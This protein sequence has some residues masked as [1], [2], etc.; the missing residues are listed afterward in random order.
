MQERYDAAAVEQAAQAYW[1]QHQ[2]YLARE[3]ASRPKYYCLSMF[4]YPSGRL[5]M[6]HVRNY[7]IGDVLARFMRMRGC[8]VLQPMG[9]DAFGL[10]AEN[11][12][13]ANGVPPAAWTR[14]NIDYMR[15]QLRSLGFAIDW[16]RELATCDPEYYRWNQWLFLR[17]LERGIAYKRTGLVNWDPVDKTV[18]ANEQVIDGRGWR[19][20]APVEK[21]EIPMYY[22]RITA[23]AEELLAAL[24]DLPGWP[25]RVRVMQAHWIGR[26]EGVELAFPY[27]AD[28]CSLL[29][30]DGALKVFTTRADTLFGVTFVAVSAEHPLAAAAAADNAPL[31][32]FVDECRRG[33]TMEADVAA[34]PKRGM[35]TGLHV[36]HPFGGQPIEVWVANYVLMAYGEG[37]VMGVP[38]HDERDFDF[39]RSHGIP[40]RTVVQSAT[41]AYQL[42]GEQWQDAYRE[43]G[44][45]IDSGRFSGLESSAAID[46]ITAALEQLGLG[47]KRVQWRLR[48]WGI[49]RQRYWGCPIPLIHCEQCGAVPVPD[50]Q[51]PVV[52]PENLVPDGS[53]NPL[54]RDAAFVN[55][56]CPACG[57]PARRETDTMDTF[58]DS[59][60]YFLRFASADQKSAPVDERA[61]Y[62]LPVDQYIG[63]IEHAILHLL[64]SRFWTRVMR[65]MG[66]VDVSEPFA[67]LLTQGMVLNHI[68]YRAPAQ[69][70]R[71]FFNPAEVQAK[72]DAAGVRT[73]GVLLADQ[74]PVEYGGL[75][76]MS[77]SKNNGVDPQTLV[78][79]YGADTARLFMMFAAPPEQSLEWSDDGVQG[80]ARFLRRLWKAVYDHV[81]AGAAPAP[82][83]AAVPPAA[84]ELRRL[85][86]QTLAK[87][88]GDIARRRTFNTAIAAVMELLNAVGHYADSGDAARVVRQEALE[89]A[90]LALSPIVP[91]ICH[92]LW[93]ALGHAGAVIDEPWP[94]P[95]PGALAQELVDLVVQVNGKLRGR[96]RL[97]AGAPRQVAVDAALADPD[98][99]RF[100][101]GKE[102]RRAV[103]VPDKLVNLVV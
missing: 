68:Y 103:H 13:I 60:W 82:A 20:G 70:R 46:A 62:W 101:A 7:T 67:R 74:Q 71:Q 85:A 51:L 3:D 6:G 53:G 64:Y 75:G 49:S 10:P 8:N 38:A 52:L 37:A 41:G 93:H 83:A 86:H 99:Q 79:K 23:Y 95:D 2:S 98:V 47:R 81:A 34:A 32:A 31:A 17:M 21:R 92:A 5:H 29:G 54:L 90:V 30:A 76:T 16:R 35:P 40:I 15:R 102:I 1:E 89:I 43:P 65:D 59:S 27:A 84:R 4:P 14:D 19:T 39:A 36:R 33:S 94:E 44:V 48:D 55:V 77:K 42:V 57:R 18:L 9:W 61:K 11:A 26:S 25:E 80:Q 28:T 100:I 22:L 72:F 66:L 12:A 96:V 45:L 24:D 97:P 91:H 78:E 63:G 50:D 56:P 88:T 58:V 87:V 69:G 73:G